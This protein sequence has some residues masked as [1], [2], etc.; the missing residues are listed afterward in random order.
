MELLKSDWYK[1]LRLKKV[2]EECHGTPGRAAG[3]RCT[4][5]ELSY[6][7]FSTYPEIYIKDRIEKFRL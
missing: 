5:L 6:H 7:K 2:I 3:S 1:I 4:P